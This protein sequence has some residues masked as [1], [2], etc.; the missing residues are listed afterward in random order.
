M[1]KTSYYWIC[2]GG[3]PEF[4]SLQQ[5]KTSRVSLQK[6][7]ISTQK[8]LYKAVKEGATLCKKARVKKVVKKYR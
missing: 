1:N 5:R 6:D 3:P 8:Q 4:F 7:M 2:I